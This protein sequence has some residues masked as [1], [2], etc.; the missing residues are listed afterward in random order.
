M[1]QPELLRMVADIL[2]GLRVP[3][4]VTGSC[5]GTIHGY[6]RSTHDVDLVVDMSEKDVIPF[7][8]AFPAPEFFVQESAVRD[9]IRRRSMF[10]LLHEATGDKADFWMRSDQQF[11]DN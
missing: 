9:A 8:A 6:M 7:L 4:M 10:N 11:Q 1:S 3:F 5:A 2:D